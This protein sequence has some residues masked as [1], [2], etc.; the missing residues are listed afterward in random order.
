MCIKT[1]TRGAED[2]NVDVWN[3]STWI[4]V[5]TDLTPNSWNNISVSSYLNL[6]NFTIRF[7][8]GNETGDTTL[9]SWN[10]DATLLHIWFSDSTY[11][12][13]LQVAN[14]VA[15]AW[16]VSLTVYDNLS[17][18]RILNMTISF[19]DGTTSDQIIV[20]N[21]TVTQSEGPLYDLAASTTIY[22]SITNLQASA[23]GISYLYVYLKIL[24]PETSTYTLYPIIFKIT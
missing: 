9:D 10:I 13:V 6:S 21:G 11:D 2:I 19:H 17:V 3:G 22:I 7:K 1:G 18:A 5:F 16:D 23:S 15:D 8:G 4:T 14:R 24:V 12:Y 20:D